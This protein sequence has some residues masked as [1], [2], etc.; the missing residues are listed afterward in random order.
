[1]FRTDDSRCVFYLVHFSPEAMFEA[2]FGLIECLRVFEGV[3]MCKHTHDSRKTMD[4]TDVEEL[5]GLHLKAKTS[6]YQHQDLLKRKY[7]Y[8]L[9]LNLTI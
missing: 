7:L 8:Y 9:K 5:K 3:Q 6:I 1:M 4:L 2:F